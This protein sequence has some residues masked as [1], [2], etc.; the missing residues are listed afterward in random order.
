MT[1]DVKFNW[2]LLIDSTHLIYPF[3][4]VHTLK[5]YY[6]GNIRC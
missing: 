1:E 4:G 2:T 3:T 6:D 5:D